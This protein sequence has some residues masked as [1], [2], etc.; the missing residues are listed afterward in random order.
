L[1]TIQWM[2]IMTISYAWTSTDI[3]SGFTLVTQV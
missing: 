2:P 3:L 1:C